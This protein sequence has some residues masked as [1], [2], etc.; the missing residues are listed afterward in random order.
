MESN[1]ERMPVARVS[2][3]SAPDTRRLGNRP[4]SFRPRSWCRL[5][6]CGW[7]G[8]HGNLKS[9]IAEYVTAT[10][11][12]F[13]PVVAFAPDSPTINRAYI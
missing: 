8:S 5:R 1:T 13:T 2:V 11:I 3:V 12:T 6:G 4:S 7:D 9:P 10:S